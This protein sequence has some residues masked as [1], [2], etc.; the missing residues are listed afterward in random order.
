MR[1]L[2]HVVTWKTSEFTSKRNMRDLG[3]VHLT[4]AL[5]Q[6]SSSQYWTCVDGTGHGARIGAFLV[7]T[8][9]RKSYAKKNAFLFSIKRALILP[10]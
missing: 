1:N 3:R 7:D 6:T 4:P 8:C 5:L 10:L 2:K 9:G